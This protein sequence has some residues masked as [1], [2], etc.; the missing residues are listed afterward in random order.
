MSEKFSVRY[1]WYVL[2]TL[3]IIV[4]Q[5]KLR[6]PSEISLRCLNQFVKKKK[7][8]K[9]KKKRKYAQC[10]RTL[11][12]RVRS[13]LGFLHQLNLRVTSKPDLDLDSLL[14]LNWDSFHIHL[15]IRF[16]AGSSGIR[17]GP[18]ILS[19]FNWENWTWIVTPTPIR[20][21]LGF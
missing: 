3:R 18:K 10:T 17:F 15:G 9:K 21:G 14:D 7:K 5:L 11:R 1:W 12:S 2:H 20:L 8:K 4:K 19:Q 6:D 13:E 16:G